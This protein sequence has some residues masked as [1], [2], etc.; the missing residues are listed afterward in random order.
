MRDVRYQETL[1]EFMTQQYEMAR[2]D[3]A[4][5]AQ[6]IQVVDPALVPD[7]RSW[8]LRTV[9]TL[10]AFILGGIIASF[11]VILQSAYAR[12]ME[13]PEAAAKI[14]QLHELLRPRIRRS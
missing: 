14:H 10:L 2:V 1:F 6:V 4:K 5:Q 13:D 7:R 12:K 9:L 8:P 11:W 3:E